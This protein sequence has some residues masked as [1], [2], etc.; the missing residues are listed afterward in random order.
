MVRTQ[1][2][3]LLL[4]GMVLANNAGYDQDDTD[5]KLKEAEVKALLQEALRR[6][7]AIGQDLKQA[8]EAA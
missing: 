2:I 3:A 4:I 8:L 6:D 5:Q 1:L 7:T